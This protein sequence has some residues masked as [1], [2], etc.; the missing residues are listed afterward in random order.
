M[1]GFEPV[2]GDEQAPR[3]EVGGVQQVAD[4]HLA[5]G[6]EAV[7]ATGEIAVPHVA[8]DGDAGVVGIVDGDDRHGAAPRG[9]KLARS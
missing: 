7:A 5:L 1:A 4:H 8:I 6:D 2:G 3:L 9:L